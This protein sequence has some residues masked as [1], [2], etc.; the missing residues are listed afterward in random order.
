[1]LVGRGKGCAMTPIIYYSSTWSFVPRD[2]VLWPSFLSVSLTQDAV[3]NKFFLN[4]GQRLVGLM[5]K[6]LTLQREYI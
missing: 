4:P 6:F 5:R 3:E 1:M 2:L